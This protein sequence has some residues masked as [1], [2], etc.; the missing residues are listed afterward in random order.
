ML[1]RIVEV[2][3]DNRHLSLFRG[4]LLVKST[5]GDKQEIGRVPIDDIAAVI[6][7]SHGLSY[8]NNL[9]VALAE[10]GSPFVLCAA[11][12]NAV[13]MLLPLDGNYEVSRRIDAQIEAKR[14]LKKQLW[15]SIVRSK[16]EQQASVLQAIGEP[17][18]PISSL[19][20][21]VKSGDPE[22][23]EAQAARRYWTLLFGSSFRRDRQA[24][25]INSL[26]NYGYTVL[27]A[28]VARAVVAAGLHPAIGLHHSNA[29]NAMRLVDDLIEPFR[30][31]VDLGVFRLT[32]INLC[33]ITPETKRVLVRLMYEDVITSSGTTPV[34][35]S[36]QKLAVSL[37]Q[38][39][40]GER[41]KLDLPLSSEPFILGDIIN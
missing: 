17:S 41:D 39:F 16:L 32:Q 20:K 28:T 27:R 13:G 29:M 33:E 37:A 15:S 35:V 19:I 31:L 36:A 4:F 22:N 12:H 8:S 7:N 21:K 1:G 34:T 11:N 23:I 18:V 26:L 10:Q 2:A 6:A 24:D 14:P 3:E 30:P 9:L 40:L 25:G 5:E 38:I